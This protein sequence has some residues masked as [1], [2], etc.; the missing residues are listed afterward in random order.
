M[1]L[2]SEIIHAHIFIH[3]EASDIK[4][5][6][7]LNKISNEICK[8]YIRDKLIIG[9]S[10]DMRQ[11]PPSFLNKLIQTRTNGEINRD[12]SAIFFKSFNL[13]EKAKKLH[14]MI[15]HNPTRNFL[16]KVSKLVVSKIILYNCSR[17]PIILPKKLKE[18]VIS[19]YVTARY[20]PVKYPP[21]LEK[22]KFPNHFDQ[23]IILPDTLKTLIFG[24]NF[25]RII[26]LPPKL[27]KLIFG[28]Y[29]NKPTVFPDSL[30]SLKF[31]NRYN[32]STVLFLQ[33]PLKD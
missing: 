32:Q 9:F 22:L 3:L 15:P 27:Q 4:S 6:R 12:T 17:K 5:Y 21:F 23:T 26:Q 7:L 29:Y 25:N 18:L 30:V 13:Y 20:V 2:P 33:G 8:I 16:L 19:Q 10:Q 14:V 28:Y 11:S 24:L 1:E 31:G